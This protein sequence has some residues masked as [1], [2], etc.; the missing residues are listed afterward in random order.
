MKDIKTAV[1]GSLQYNDRT[2]EVLDYFT[3]I[4]E[5]ALIE[6]WDEELERVGMEQFIGDEKAVAWLKKSLAKHRKN[7]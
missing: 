7:K 5:T 1:C 2:G 4:F 3:N 6:G